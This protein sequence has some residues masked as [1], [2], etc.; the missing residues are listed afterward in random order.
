MHDRRMARL[1]ERVA[2]HR[3]E[4]VRGGRQTWTLRRQ[5]AGVSKWGSELPPAFLRMVLEQLEWDAADCGAMR[6]TCSM[7][8]DIHDTWCPELYPVRWTAVMEGKM[9][10]FPSVTKVNMVCCEKED[11]GSNLVELRS[12]P[13]LRSLELPAICA[14]REVDAVALYGHARHAEVL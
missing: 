8:S 9:G 1:R 12:M 13:T 4:A 3:T 11:I 14:E 6:A 7:W 10:R 2:F 5:R